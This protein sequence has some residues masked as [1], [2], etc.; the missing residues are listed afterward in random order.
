LRVR[1]FGG[2]SPAIALDARFETETDAEHAFFDVAKMERTIDRLL[3]EDT[4]DRAAA[5]RFREQLSAVRVARS[6]RDVAVNL[7]LAPAFA[8]W[9]R[10]EAQKELAS[11]TRP[12]RCD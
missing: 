12:A 10:G 9:L 3:D 4:K 6:G 2:A 5:Q 8:G 11:R 1:V 7:H